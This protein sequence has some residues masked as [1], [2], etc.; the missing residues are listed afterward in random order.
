MVNR[1]WRIFNRVTKKQT[2]AK[3]LTNPL[4]E[5]AQELPRIR[6]N[7][8]GEPTESFVRQLYKKDDR[9]DDGSRD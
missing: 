1:I 3:R 2:E 5:E 6:F 9:E 4:Q 7:D 8:E